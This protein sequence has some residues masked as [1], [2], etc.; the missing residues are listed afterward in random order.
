MTA[1][2]AIR[3]ETIP[4]ALQ[5]PIQAVVE[6]GGKHYCLLTRGAAPIE[7]R[8]VLIGSTNEKFLVIRDGLSRDD[9]VLLNPRVHLAEVLPGEPSAPAVP[10]KKEEQIAAKQPP[11]SPA[12]VPRPVPAVTRGPGL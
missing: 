5:V 9:A 4:D 11:D 6:R 2:V 12:A 10:G 3:V 1:K 7:A 8:E